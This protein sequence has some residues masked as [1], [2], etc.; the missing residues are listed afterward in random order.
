ML[1]T[2]DKKVLRK[3]NDKQGYEKEVTKFFNRGEPLCP[4]H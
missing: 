4:T 3:P 2:H 1:D